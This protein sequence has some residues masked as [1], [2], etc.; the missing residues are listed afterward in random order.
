[1]LSMKFKK[2]KEKTFVRRSITGPSTGIQNR[3]S[4]WKFELLDGLHSV[5]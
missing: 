4:D 5:Y 1:M 2:K 3:L